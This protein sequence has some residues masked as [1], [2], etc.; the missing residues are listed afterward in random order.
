MFSVPPESSEKGAW[1]A[2]LR[3]DSDPQK[4]MRLPDAPP[5][6]EV[7]LRD[8]R[9]ALGG[10]AALGAITAFAISGAGEVAPA[11]KSYPSPS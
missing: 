2:W 1:R 3:P 11:Y 8:A 5:A 6:P 10:E 4:P 7:L 9:A